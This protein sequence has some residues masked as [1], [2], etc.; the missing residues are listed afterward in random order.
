M[1]W[2]RPMRL[3]KWALMGFVR[4]RVKK[5]FALFT[6]DYIIPIP[7]AASSVFASPRHAMSARHRW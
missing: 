6:R 2:I 3:L 7:M 4:A 1:G 5:Q